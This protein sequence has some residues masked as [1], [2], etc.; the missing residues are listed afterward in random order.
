MIMTAPK[1]ITQ[2]IASCRNFNWLQW[3]NIFNYDYINT[4]FNIS[5]FFVFT[6]QKNLSI[7]YQ[8]FFLSSLSSSHISYTK[9]HPLSDTG[10][11]ESF[12]IHLRCFPSRCSC[13]SISCS[14]ATLWY[15]MKEKLDENQCHGSAG[16]QK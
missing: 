8:F 6:K 14:Y 11:T 15:S 13:S 16:S 4:G 1:T 2:C 7:H 3:D 9:M 5:F 10:C 12:F